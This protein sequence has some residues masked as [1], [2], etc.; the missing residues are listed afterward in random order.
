MIVQWNVKL[1]IFLYIIVGFLIRLLK[2]LHLLCKAD[3]ISGGSEVTETAYI[4]K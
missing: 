2:R 4:Y 1:F 3:R